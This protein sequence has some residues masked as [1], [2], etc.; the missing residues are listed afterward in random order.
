MPFLGAGF[1]VSGA[2]ESAVG[3]GVALK[4]SETACFVTEDFGLLAGNPAAPPHGEFVLPNGV[5]VLGFDE[6]G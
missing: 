6:G 4:T 1:A 3:G 5:A 2:V